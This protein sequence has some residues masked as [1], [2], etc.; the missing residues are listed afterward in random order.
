MKNAII[1]VFG[2]RMSSYTSFLHEIKDDLVALEGKGD[3]DGAF[4]RARIDKLRQFQ[5][6]AVDIFGNPVIQSMMK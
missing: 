4:I 2:K 3:G 6:K 5:Q 1:D